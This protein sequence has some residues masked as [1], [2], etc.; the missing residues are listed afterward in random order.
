MAENFQIGYGTLYAGDGTDATYEEFTLI[1]APHQFRNGLY[2]ATEALSSGDAVMQ[3][4]AAGLSAKQTNGDVSDIF[5]G[6]TLQQVVTSN[7]YYASYVPMINDV[8]SIAQ[9][10]VAWFTKI[11]GSVSHGDRLILSSNGS[12]LGGF[13]TRGVDTT[14]PV[15]GRTDSGNSSSGAPILA[16]ISA[17]GFLSIP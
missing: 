6:I 15:V 5:L 11:E 17:L 4:T 13:V 8:I 16:T 14:H 9:F 3:D 10:C 1:S 7:A 2:K 12:Y